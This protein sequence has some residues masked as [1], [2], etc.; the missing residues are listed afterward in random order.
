MM[1]FTTKNS[2]YHHPIHINF[3]FPPGPQEFQIWWIKPKS[4]IVEEFLKANWTK[5]Q[6]DNI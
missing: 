6:Q 3:S 5:K 2:G 1:H 4:M